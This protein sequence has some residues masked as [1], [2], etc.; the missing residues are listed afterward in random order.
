MVGYMQG[1]KRARNTPSITN[2][3]KIFGIMGGLAPRVG[4]SNAG[5]YNH[6]VIKGGRGLPQLYGKSIKY[7]KNYLFTNKLLSV[8][9]VGSGGVGKGVLMRQFSQAGS[10]PQGGM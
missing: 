5:T 2:N 1:S 6:Q 4:L 7:Q 3:T 8:N 9:P 10:A